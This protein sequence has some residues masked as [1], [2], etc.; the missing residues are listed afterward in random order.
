MYYPSLDMFWI[1]RCPTEHKKCPTYLL[2][3]QNR[4]Q[5]LKPRWWCNFT[6]GPCRALCIICSH[7]IIFHWT[8]CYI[9]LLTCAMTALHLEPS[10]DMFTDKFLIAMERSVSCW[11]LHHTIYSD[12]AAS[13]QASC[14]EL[15]STIKEPKTSQYFPHRQITWKFIAPQATWWRVWWDSSN[16]SSRFEYSHRGSEDHKRRSKAVFPTTWG[17]C[18]RWSPVEKG[19]QWCWKGFPVCAVC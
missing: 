17:T 15:A 5:C 3:T 13:I 8:E 6:S 19:K 11:G 18:D 7:W 2:A 9:L 4:Q 14:R 10:T 16:N 1:L 12:N